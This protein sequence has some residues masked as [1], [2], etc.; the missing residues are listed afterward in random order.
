M[1]FFLQGTGF[2]TVMLVLYF[3]GLLGC[4][5]ALIYYVVKPLEIVQA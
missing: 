3:L 1:I 2:R 5:V 4:A